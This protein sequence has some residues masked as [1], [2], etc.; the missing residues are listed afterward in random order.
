MRRDDPHEKEP[1]LYSGHDLGSAR[2]AFIMLH[3]RGASPRDILSVGQQLASDQIAL[4]APQAAEHSWYP[5]SF[6]APLTQNQPWLESALR[7]IAVCV[8]ECTLAGIPSEQI[9]I[10]GFSQGACLG[11]EFVARHPMRYGAV[12]AFTGGLLGP[13]G[14][15]LEH[16]GNMQGTPMLLTSGDPDL[17]V[18]WQR[19]EESAEA[20]GRMGAIV[21][22]VRHQDRPHTVLNSELRLAKDLLIWSSLVPA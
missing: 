11:T 6:L 4:I 7:K 18:P 3:G 2:S 5:H 9:A 14:T 21:H 10:I 17:H 13:L 8:E 20:L 1:V 16:P 15:S 19:V 22:L 12:I